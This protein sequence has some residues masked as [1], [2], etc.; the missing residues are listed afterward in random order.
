[1]SRPTAVGA[2]RKRGVMQAEHMACP[3]CGADADHRSAARPVYFQE[4]DTGVKCLVNESRC[5]RRA[6]PLHREVDSEWIPDSLWE[7]TY[8]VLRLIGLIP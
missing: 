2:P 3:W 1:M 4:K 5:S 7:T 8:D 6:C